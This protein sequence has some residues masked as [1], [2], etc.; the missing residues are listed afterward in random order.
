MPIN[1]PQTANGNATVES[2]SQS[3]SARIERFKTETISCGKS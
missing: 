3:D 2:N 1:Q